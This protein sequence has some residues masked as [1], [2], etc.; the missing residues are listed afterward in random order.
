MDFFWEEG[1]LKSGILWA[2]FQQLH[3]GD[4]R[5]HLGGQKANG[6]PMVGGSSYQ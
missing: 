3:T 1:N 5:C 2:F 6:R 4:W